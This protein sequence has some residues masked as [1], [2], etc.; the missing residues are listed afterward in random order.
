MPAFPLALINIRDR[1][2]PH[3]NALVA[4]L[5]GKDLPAES[6]IAGRKTARSAMIALAMALGGLTLWATLA[7]LSGAAIVTGNVIV[8]TQRKTVNHLEGGIVKNILVTPGQRVAKDEP[9]VVLEDVVQSAA[10]TQFRDALDAALAQAS[11]LTAEK[12]NQS[13]TEF[14]QELLSRAA[15]PKV[16]QILRNEEV[17][18][19]ARLASLNES[20]RLLKQQINE[21]GAQAAQLVEQAAAAERTLVIARNELEKAKKLFEQK[22]VSDTALM[23]ARRTVAEREGQRAVSTADLEEVRAKVS[24]L[25]LQLATVYDTRSKEAAQELR[26]TEKKI[27]ELR[28]QLRPT[29][30]A[31]RR[32][33]VTAPIAGEVIDLKIHTAGGVIQPGEALMDIIPAD[34]VLIVE[35]LL[36]SRQIEE[37]RIGQVVEVELSA[38][39]RRITPLVEGRLSYIAGDALPDPKN[40]MSHD[41]YYTV[42]VEIDPESVKRVGDVKVMLGMPITAFIK[43]RERS[44]FDYLFEPVTDLLRRSMR[45]R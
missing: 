35:G 39:R 38:Y 25:R 2:I 18:F 10:T 16:A 1:L 14:P 28:E 23:T 6:M 31:L 37:V 24:A 15:D 27:F 8:A 5:G 32:R 36:I 33:I 40:P 30:D 43:T 17:F 9:L 42:R 11:R 12:L 45:E 44:A 41:L 34:E 21:T 3:V 13:K 20:V 4:F 26:D 29:E 7:P 22:Y 19:K